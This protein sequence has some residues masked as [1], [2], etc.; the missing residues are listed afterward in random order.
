MPRAE[1]SDAGIRCTHVIASLVRTSS[2]VL[3]LAAV[4]V[5]THVRSGW[6]THGDGAP[7]ALADTRAWHGVVSAQDELKGT[8]RVPGAAAR[9][10]PS[11]Q[12]TVSGVFDP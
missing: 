10:T 9:A 8:F 4:S 12:K 7:V 6:R 2:L 11:W 3:L 1:V 5:I